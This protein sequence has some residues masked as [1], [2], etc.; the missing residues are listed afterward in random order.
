[1]LYVL[2]QG[3]FFNLGF[4]Q[5]PYAHPWTN[6]ILPSSVSRINPRQIRFGRH[7]HVIVGGFEKL[8]LAIGK[9]DPTP[10]IPIDR[11]PNRERCERDSAH[12][13]YHPSRYGRIAWR[14]RAFSVCAIIPNEIR[15]LWEVF[16]VL[17]NESCHFIAP[18][19]RRCHRASR[20]LSVR[21]GE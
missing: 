8:I 5:C 11:P 18:G 13:S 6:P 10:S 15:L 3:L 7:A 21:R 17:K 1:M 4:N 20:G 19:T 14:K 16:L 2:R 9:I 12:I